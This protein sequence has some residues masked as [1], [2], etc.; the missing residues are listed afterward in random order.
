MTLTDEQKKR[1]RLGIGGSEIAA[2]VG[3]H[4]YMR[5]IDVYATKVEGREVEDNEHMERGRFF[6]R[7]TAEWYAHRTGATLRETGT[8][9]HPDNPLVICTPDF[10]AKAGG[11][12]HDLSIKVPGPR[13]Y[14]EWGEDG[15]DQAP[16]AYLLQ[17]QWELIP[18][19]RLEGIAEAVIAAP[20]DGQLR[21]YPVKADLECQ[22]WLIEAAERFWRNHV[23]PK[24]PPD[25]DASD[26]YSEFIRAKYPREDGP[27]IRADADAEQWAAELARARADL[28]DAEGR[29]TNA[30]NWLMSIIGPAAGIE[31]EGWRIHYKTTKPARKVQWE[32]LA[33]HLGATDADIEG[34]TTPG[35]SYRTFRPTFKRGDK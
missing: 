1:R 6:E 16:D 32:A 15:T 5:P 10:L 3:A 33:R 26:N 28:A 14:G 25:P 8:I 22:S 7:P 2:L 9:V 31:G 13:T 35:K 12:E 18:L 11:A 30:R 27:I 17:V 23:E 34:F 4:K 29:E 24:R 19:Q 21:R 20:V